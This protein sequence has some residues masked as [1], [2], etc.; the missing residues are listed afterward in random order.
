MRLDLSFTLPSP[1]SYLVLTGILLTGL[2][3]GSSESGPE[4]GSELQAS[5]ETPPD[6][7]RTAVEQAVTEVN[8]MRESRAATIGE[9]KIDRQ[10][11][12]RVCMP[13][14]KRAKEIAAE[15]GWVFQQLSDKYRNPA[16]ELDPR[17]RPVYEKFSSSPQLRDTWVHTER[18]GTEGWRYYRRITVQSS[19]M[20]C[21]GAREERPEF[22]KE[23]YPQ[24][25]AYGFEPGDLRG[26]YSVFVPASGH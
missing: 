5:A 9:E 21:H 1:L 19:C 26:V 3:C 17:S 16:H 22:V 13:V 8:Q 14:G 12:A 20:G 15:R 23:S 10:T 7:I 2:G 18:E 4:G 11:F 24:D 6:S 25:R